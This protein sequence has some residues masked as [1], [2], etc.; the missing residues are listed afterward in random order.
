[1][2]RPN[3]VTSYQRLPSLRKRKP[4]I[5]SRRFDDEHPHE[6][7]NKVS[8]RDRV[9]IVPRLLPVNVFRCHVSK[10]ASILVFAALT[11]QPLNFLAVAVDLVLIA[12]D[13]L[14]LL[15]IGILLALQLVTDQRTC[16]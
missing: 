5:G 2:S 14:L 16:A 1:M 6:R 4:G 8:L 11:L 7:N 13:L 3:W 12:I 10:D 9:R 15:V